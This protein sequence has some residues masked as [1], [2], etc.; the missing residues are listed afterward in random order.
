MDKYFQMHVCINQPDRYYPVD[1][2]NKNQ[3]T[4]SYQW[5]KMFGKRL[6]K[7]TIKDGLYYNSNNIISIANIPLEKIKIYKNII[8]HNARSE[9]ANGIKPL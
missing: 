2:V 3:N 6:A 4:L 5:Y 9:T 1:F 7:I 8:T